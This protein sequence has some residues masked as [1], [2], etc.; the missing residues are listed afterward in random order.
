M[1]AS[2]KERDP[3]VELLKRAQV[4]KLA[5]TARKKSIS[6]LYGSR[7]SVFRGV[8]TDFSETREY[9]PGDDLRYIDWGA[10][11]RTPNNLIIKEFE[12]ERNTSVTVL[13]DTSNSMTLGEPITRL[14]I[15]AEASATLSYAALRGR[16]KIGFVSFSDKIH[17]F[18]RPAGGLSHFYHIL[19]TL[20]NITPGGRTDLGTVLKTTALTVP[21][22]SLILL[23]TDLHD[24]K[25]ESVAGF[26]LCNALKHEVQVMHI[27]EPSEYSTLAA[28]NEV[29]FEDPKDPGKI[30]TLDLKD[31]LTRAEFMYEI[32]ERSQKITQFIR[33][34]RGL[35]VRVIDAPTTALVRKVLMAYYTSKSKNILIE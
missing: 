12:Q 16:D 6:T 7:R 13:L 1:S 18:I 22:R 33:E 28:T 34:L 30:V 20:V 27:H 26:K 25:D 4:R 14:K 5:I 24:L 10:S 21:K 19:N 8:G 17:N 31:Q 3:R 11:A 15:A 32:Y 35:K 29:K 2:E 9:V 23:V